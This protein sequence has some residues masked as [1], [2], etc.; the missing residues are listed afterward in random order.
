MTT[1]IAEQARLCLSFDL[2]HKHHDGTYS[3]AG[4][5][6]EKMKRS[7]FLYGPDGGRGFYIGGFRTLHLSKQA[8]RNHHA[9][10]LAGPLLRYYRSTD[11]SKRL[12]GES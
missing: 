6:I 10:E 9:Q 3:C 5:K 7:W 8:A 12:D 1:T 2:W 11:L 4:Y